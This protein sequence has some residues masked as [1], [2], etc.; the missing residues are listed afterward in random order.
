MYN[1]LCIILLNFQRALEVESR[2]QWLAQHCCWSGILSSVTFSLQ[3]FSFLIDKGAIVLW[4]F[5]KEKFCKVKSYRN[6][7]KLIWNNFRN[8]LIYINLSHLKLYWRKVKFKK[9][10]N[11]QY[12]LYFPFLHPTSLWEWHSYRSQQDFTSV[13]MAPNLSRNICIFLHQTML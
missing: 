12:F 2:G 4:G 11:L 13:S 5:L 7:R 9:E 3:E 6:Y 1:E 10:N 8:H